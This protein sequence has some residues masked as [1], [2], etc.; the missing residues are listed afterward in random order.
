MNQKGL[1]GIT[2]DAFFDSMVLMFQLNSSK[3]ATFNNDARFAPNRVHM[4]LK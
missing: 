2:Y 1:I 4:W 3:K